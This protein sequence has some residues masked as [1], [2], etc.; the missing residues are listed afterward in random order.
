MS[1]TTIDRRQVIR[2][3][4]DRARATGDTVEP[5]RSVPETDHHFAGTDEVLDALHRE[6]LRAVVARLHRG[7]IVAE[8]SP[9]A[10]R[11]LYA[12]IRAAHPTI[13][14]ILD[15]HA[16]DPALTE[17]MQREH[18]MLARLSGLVPEH[19]PEHLA[20]AVGRWL[21]EGRFPFQRPS[22]H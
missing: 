1:T 17:A 4:L 14:R 7:E 2:A 15:E 18:A 11:E 3:V 16:S 5:W 21:L 8:R 20:A 6:W 13:R 10:V 19:A 12:E 9:H 22:T